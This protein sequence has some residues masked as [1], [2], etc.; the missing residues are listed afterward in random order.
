ML[1]FHDGDLLA[2]ECVSSKLLSGRWPESAAR[3]MARVDG[4]VQDALWRAQQA[5]RA[6]WAALVCSVEDGHVLRDHAMAELREAVAQNPRQLVELVEEGH[7][8]S[9]ESLELLRERAAEA[10]GAPTRGPLTEVG[11]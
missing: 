7:A 3:V 11:D 6:S 5:A 2:H 8:L 10:A 4:V 1:V 9:A